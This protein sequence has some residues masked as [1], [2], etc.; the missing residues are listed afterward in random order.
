M[1]SKAGVRNGMRVM[2][3]EDDRALGLFLQKGLALDGFETEWLG[4]GKDALERLQVDQ[5]EFMILDLS[6][7]GCDGIEILEDLRAAQKMPPVLVLTGRNNVEERI[8]CLN[9]GA[10]DCLLKP[11]SFQELSARC[12]AILRRRGAPET[13]SLHHGPIEVDLVN[14]KAWCNRQLI[15]LTAKEFVLL[16]FL[17]QRKGQC[18]FREELLR[19]VWQF[20]DGAASNVIEVYINYLRRKL[21]ATSPLLAGSA[22]LIETVRGSGYRLATFP[23]SV[24]FAGAC[25]LDVGMVP[26]AMKATC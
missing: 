1:H 15:D 19:E 20:R 10:D 13:R 11:F 24:P 6:L 22:A 5:P 7:P 18:C 23:A 25:G 14:R 2:I 9:L 17:V 8:R 12:R 3:V 21:A 4:N 26:E 16:A